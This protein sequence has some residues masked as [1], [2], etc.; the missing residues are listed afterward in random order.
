MREKCLHPNLLCVCEAGSVLYYSLHGYWV[1]RMFAM[2]VYVNT[3][4]EL[5]LLQVRQTLD[6]LNHH[7]N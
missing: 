4:S 5:C 2:Y 7:N 1:G 3:I 6:L